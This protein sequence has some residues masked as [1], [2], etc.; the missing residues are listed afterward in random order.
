MLVVI[1]NSNTFYYTLDS[2]IE[3]INT[4]ADL[5]I[6]MDPSKTNF[7]MVVGDPM[8][9]VIEI[10]EFSGNGRSKGKA[11]DTTLYCLEINQFSSFLVHNY[12]TAIIAE[13]SG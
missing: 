8:G 13:T 4:N 7:A 3:P 10:V 11:Q 1:N 2:Y 6:A 12:P 5:V 9:N